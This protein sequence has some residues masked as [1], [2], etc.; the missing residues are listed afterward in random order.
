MISSMIMGLQREEDE[1]EVNMMLNVHRTVRLIR[2]GMQEKVSFTILY[3][4]RVQARS[5]GGR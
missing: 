2:D 1:E 4:S 3:V 5:R